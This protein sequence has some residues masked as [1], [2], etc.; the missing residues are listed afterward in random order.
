M[1]TTWPSTLRALGLECGS[2]CFKPRSAPHWLELSSLTSTL[3]SSGFV[4]WQG[5]PAIIF[6]EM[7]VRESQTVLRVS[8]P[9]CQAATDFL[10]K[11]FA[12]KDCQPRKSSPSRFRKGYFWIFLALKRVPFS[13]GFKFLDGNVQLTISE[14]KIS[15]PKIFRHMPLNWRNSNAGQLRFLIIVGSTRNMN[16]SFV[17]IHL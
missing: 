11:T 17:A 15:F 3:I 6:G 9:C 7:C 16:T 8:V 10:T 12:Y 4:N 5:H 2:S 13:F 14:M 1:N